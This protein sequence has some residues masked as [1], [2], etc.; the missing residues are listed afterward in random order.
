MFLQVKEANRSVLETLDGKAPPINGPQ[1]QRVAEGQRMMQAA[2]DFF[3]GWTE[4]E[5]SG[6]QYYVRI[7]KNRRSAASAKSA[8]AEGLGRLLHGYAAARWRAPTPARAIR[9]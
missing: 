7:L 2:S 4:Y 5:K 3:L 1:G 8:K 6:R 9:R